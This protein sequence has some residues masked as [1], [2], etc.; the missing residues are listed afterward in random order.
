[1]RAFRSP[2]RR[3]PTL[4]IAPVSPT[5][6]MLSIQPCACQGP[7]Q[8]HH[9]YTTF[10]LDSDTPYIINTRVGQ[11]GDEAS[12]TDGG[13]TILSPITVALAFPSNGAGREMPQ[14]WIDEG[15]DGK[16]SG[17]C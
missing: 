4:S 12:G 17:C 5:A 16:D 8:I 1:M 7:T 14:D 6:C 15:E 9:S 13:S 3:Q 2:L 10:L 11:K